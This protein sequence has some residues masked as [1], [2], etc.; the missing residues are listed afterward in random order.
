MATGFSTIQRNSVNK[1]PGYKTL[2]ERVTEKSIN[3]IFETQGEG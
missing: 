3:D 2:F 1:D